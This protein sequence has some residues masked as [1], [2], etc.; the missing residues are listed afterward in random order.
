MQKILAPDFF[1]FGRSGRTYAR[2]DTLYGSRSHEINAQIPLKDFKVHQITN[3]V[4][5]IT[6]SSEVSNNNEIERGNRSS[7]WV[8]SNE[9]WQLRFHQGTKI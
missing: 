1:E 9:K 2:K 6:Y 3:D 8:K 7:I 5:Q 4:I